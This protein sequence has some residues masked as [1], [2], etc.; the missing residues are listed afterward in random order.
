LGF[1]KPV[2]VTVKVPA[3]PTV[4][5]ALAALVIVG[6]SFTV[7]I[8]G[9][10]AVPAELLAVKVIGYVPPVP[11]G[12]VPLSVAVPL[13]LAVNV[14]PGNGQG[15]AQPK[16]GVGVPVAVTVNVP[17]VPTVNVVLAALV[18]IGA[19][20]ADEGVIVAARAVVSQS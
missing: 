11:A 18:I 7:S 13:L 20:L 2:A 5:V 3:T 15:E 14:R 9:C 12:G 1:G 19:E 17:V 10:V 4:K 16:P 6:A 8:K